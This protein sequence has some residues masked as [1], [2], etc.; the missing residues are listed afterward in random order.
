M[1]AA[2]QAGA[3]AVKLQTWDVMTVSDHVIR[4]G[5]W[6]STRLAD[7]YER[8]RTPWEWHIPIFERCKE[9]GIHG[10]S[11]PFDEA[12]VDFLE[13][14][15]VPCYKIASFEIT[16]LPLI[17]KTAS[18]GKP[19]IISTGMATIEEIEAAVDVATT[20]GAKGITLLKCVSA[21]P[22]AVETF[23]LI[24][25]CDM[26]V[27]FGC[28]V[29]LSDHTRGSAVAVA[30]TALGAKVIEKHITLSVDQGLDD[31]FACLPEEFTAMVDSVRA[32]DLC[33]GQP[34]YG[35]SP[36]EAGSLELRRSIWVTK[37]IEA[38]DPLTRDNIAIL[39]PQGGLPPSRLPSLLGTV[40]TRS[41][42]RG[43]PL[44]A[45]LF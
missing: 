23:N 41:A 35:P 45:D 27:R 10:F 29:G 26:E 4:D 7:L 15:A 28:E 30:A 8:A 39:R 12:S 14:L 9:R 17:A 43:T 16:H 21:Y 24:T 34:C 32:A 11:T 36:D 20:N 22:A 5:P 3:D 37:D 6:A 38:G 31:G 18:T 44:T 25:M 13:T 33:L 42:A 2:A 1:D 19:L 40:A